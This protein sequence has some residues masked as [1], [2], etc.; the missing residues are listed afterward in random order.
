MKD[1]VDLMADQVSVKQLVTD[2]K[3]KVYSGEDYLPER[4]VVVSDISRP[5]L[6]L[7]GYFN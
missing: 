1:G 5:G 2:I 6:E 4:Q 7:T 3:L